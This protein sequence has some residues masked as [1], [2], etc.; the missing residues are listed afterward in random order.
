VEGGGKTL[1]TALSSGVAD[2]I[3]LFIAPRILGR[4]GVAAFS[5]LEVE[6]LDA[7]SRV[8][9]WSWRPIGPDLLVEGYLSQAK[10]RPR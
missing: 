6:D 10:E 7:A 5:G 1:G 2:R 9:D 8:R 3:A 4:R